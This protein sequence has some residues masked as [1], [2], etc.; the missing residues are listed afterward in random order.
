MK[1][2]DIVTKQDKGTYAV[3]LADGKLKIAAYAY[4]AFSWLDQSDPLAESDSGDAFMLASLSLNSA[5]VCE[6]PD[7]PSGHA[8]TKFK[9][10]H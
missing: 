5:C 6:F 4:R 10:Y 3:G 9:T 8:R 7:T 2:V 1:K